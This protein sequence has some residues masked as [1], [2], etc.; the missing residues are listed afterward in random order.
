MQPFKEIEVLRGRWGNAVMRG[1]A[2]FC[3]ICKTKN[4]KKLLLGQQLQLT[5]NQI[6]TKNEKYDFFRFRD[7]HCY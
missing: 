6:V 1:K 4:G 5:L 2:V 7:Y 3:R